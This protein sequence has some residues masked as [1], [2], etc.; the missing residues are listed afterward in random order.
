MLLAASGV[1]ALVDERIHPQS[2]PQ[3]QVDPSIRYQ[4]I[5]GQNEQNLVGVAGCKEAIL[6]ITAHSMS[7]NTAKEIAAEVESA[8]DGFSARQAFA[9][10][11]VQSVSLE[12][13]LELDDIVGDGSEHRIFEISQDY[14]FMYY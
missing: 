2:I 1:T 5:G 6:Q 10:V 4:R 7:Y 11:T 9:G 3:G 13:E 14:K 12:N 8:L